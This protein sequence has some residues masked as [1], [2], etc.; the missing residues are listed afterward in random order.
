MLISHRALRR[1]A[2]PLV[3]LCLALPAIAAIPRQAGQL[4]VL[5]AAPG[6]FLV[7]TP[8][9]ALNYFRESV[10]L[11][12]QHNHRGSMGIIINR[13]TILSMAGLLPEYSRGRGSAPLLEGGPV[14]P[15]Q[16]SL[17]MKNERLPPSLAGSGGLAF[18]FGTRP[19]LNILPAIPASAD[20]RIYSGYCGWAPGQLQSE[21]SR[22]AWLVMEGDAAL[23]FET[24]PDLLWQRMLWRV[25]GGGK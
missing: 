20:F 1:Y 9:M 10:I 23:V 14:Q 18:I 8:A 25:R 13:P 5:A 22:G 7:A 24:Y 4:P 21:I 19:V 17:L 11:L 12:T 3:T 15:T 2:F 6:R 16:L